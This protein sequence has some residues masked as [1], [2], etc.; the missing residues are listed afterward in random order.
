MVKKGLLVLTV[1]MFSVGF[2]IGCMSATEKGGG[3]VANSEVSSYAGTYV[4]QN[5][6]TSFLKLKADGSYYCIGEGPY[7]ADAAEWDVE[8]NKLV[9]FWKH[10]PPDGEAVVAG[11][12][13][14]NEII[15]SYGVWVKK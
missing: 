9:L 8:G 7:L 12:I 2:L 6:P 5:D 13:Q 4:N 14:G 1:V 15:D 3:Q 11:K 10:L